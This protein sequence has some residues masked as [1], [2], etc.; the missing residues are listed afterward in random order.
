MF[1]LFV[2]VAVLVL[3]NAELQRVPLYKA[4]SIRRSIGINHRKSRTIPVSTGIVREPLFNENDNASYYGLIT[5]GT[6]P[7]KFK[8]L[9]D[10]GSSDLW[11]PSLD[12]ISHSVAC[13]VHNRYNHE[14]SS[15]YLKNDT[16][17]N[18]V[19]GSGEVSGYLSTDVVN[20]A[21]LDVKNQTFAEIRFQVGDIFI[22]SKFDGILGLGYPELMYA[23]GVTPVFKN[24]IEQDLVKPVFSIYIN[25]SF[26]SELIG[27][28][29]L[30]GSDSNYYI[31]EFI[32]VN[33]SHK[34]HWQV[35]MDMIQIKNITL[36]PNGC[37]AVIDTGTS[38]IIGPP[39]D[40][41]I[42]NKLIGATYTEEEMMVDCNMISSLPDIYLILNGVLFKLTSED[43]IIKDVLNGT[44]KCASVF[45]TI[46]F[47]SKLI[48]PIWVL[49]QPLLHQYYIEFDMRNDRIGFA[50]R[51]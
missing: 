45:G 34:K 9:I 16:P 23:K 4:N 50:F 24:M 12:C 37:E 44:I 17:F 15:T 14:K 46:P 47:I 2:A 22:H 42:I 39:S 5:I 40:I 13:W 35:T 1:R 6:P 25:R 41:D 49:G 43:Y 21:G 3:I 33:V 48:E 20:F 31:G 36:C 10:T 18:I 8:V 26:E 32:Y 28:L 11:V 29:L 51:N 30:G 7:Q 19:Y 38:L 27:E